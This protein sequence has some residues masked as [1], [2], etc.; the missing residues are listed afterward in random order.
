M[1]RYRN[2]YRISTPVL[3]KQFI[4]CK[5]LFY[6]FYICTR[7]IDLVYCNDNA[8]A[9]SFCMADSLYCLR[10]DTVI[11]CYNK[12]CDICC[13]RTT[14]SHCS[15]CFMTRCIQE[16]NL[17]TVIIYHISTDMLCDAT[18]LTGNYIC[19]TNRVK[20]RCFTMIDMTHN[21]DNWRTFYH[22]C[23]IFFILF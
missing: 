9:C 14:H 13:L 18:G 12:D 10:H 7:L 20:Q 17:L 15:E 2:K 22:K 23:F 6:L 21:A 5:F 4:L 3:C 8:D 19:L 11:C 1:C 16:C